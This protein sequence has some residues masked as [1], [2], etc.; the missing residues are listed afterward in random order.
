MSSSP[1]ISGSLAD[2]A[3]AFMLRSP[4]IPILGEIAGVL[5]GAKASF[6]TP[7]QHVVDRSNALELLGTDDLLG[8]AARTHL[9]VEHEE[10]QTV[11]IPIED[12]QHQQLN[13]VGS[14]LGL[15]HRRLNLGGCLDPLAKHQPEQKSLFA[16]EVIIKCGL[17]ET[18]LIGDG[19]QR[20]TRRSLA[21]D[22]IEGRIENLGAGLVSSALIPGLSFGASR[23]VF[24]WIDEKNLI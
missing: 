4:R 5:I 22:D 15:I 1:W 13:G 2:A 8:F 18:E 7:V 24:V 9:V 20:E 17:C 10:F 3:I 11:T 23:V 6:S 16:V 19:R 21:K 12:R 14:V